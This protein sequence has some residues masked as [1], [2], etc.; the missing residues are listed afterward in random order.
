MNDNGH[1]MFHSSEVFI[2]QHQIFT[3]TT[4]WCVDAFGLLST[5]Q[6]PFLHTLH[7]HEQDLLRLTFAV[8]KSL[9]DG[10]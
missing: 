7:N 4:T 3:H 1:Q 10:D 2:D 9:L 8:V 5:H 6:L